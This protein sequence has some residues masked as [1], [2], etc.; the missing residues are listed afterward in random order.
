VEFS[1]AIPTELLSPYKRSEFMAW[2]RHQPIT[3]HDRLRIY[4]IYID[5]NATP[6]TADE[7]DSLKPSQEQIDAGYPQ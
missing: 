7:I 4:F 5:T 6:Y 3:F 2:L 1:D